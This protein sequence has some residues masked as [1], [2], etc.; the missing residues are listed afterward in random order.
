[1]L[2]RLLTCLC[3]LHSSAS[4]HAQRSTV[5]VPPVAHGLE[6]YDAALALNPFVLRTAPEPVKESSHLKDWT[7]ASVYGDV[8]RP[9]VVVV[10]MKT[11]ERVRLREDGGSSQG[12]RLMD[13]K[14]GVGRKDVRA[15]VDNAGEQAELSFNSEWSRQAAAENSAAK[16]APGGGRGIT[17]ARAAARQTG[18][19]LDAGGAPPAAAPPQPGA[20]T[21]NARARRNSGTPMVMVASGRSQP[22]GPGGTSPDDNQPETGGD[23]SPSDT[24]VH[25]PLASNAPIPLRRHLLRPTVLTPHPDPQ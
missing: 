23:E 7:I 24:Y 16:M 18:G 12:M 8:T 6:R 3:V 25:V 4:A 21:G 5:F 22:A 13:V 1:M 9:T 15:I 14:L 2:F 11:R 19:A 20:T 17:L 10:N